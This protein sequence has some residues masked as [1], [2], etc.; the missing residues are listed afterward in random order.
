MDCASTPSIS[1]AGRSGLRQ[2]PT[3]ESANEG[4]ALVR[5]C[6]FINLKGDTSQRKRGLNANSLTVSLCRE[7]TALLHHVGPSFPES[8]SRRGAL[9]QTPPDEMRRLTCAAPDA[10]TIDLNLEV[11]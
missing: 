1:R 9:E 2:L 10:M 3:S 6:Q 8:V 5:E 7:S 4:V 11:G